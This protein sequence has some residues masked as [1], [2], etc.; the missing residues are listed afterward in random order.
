MI[1]FRGWELPLL[2]SR[3]S[4]FILLCFSSLLALACSELQL[5]AQGLS[6]FTPAKEYVR[7]NG[8]VVAIENAVSN[9]PQLAI[10]L[11]AAKS[12]YA[13]QQTFSGWAFDA[14]A[15]IG[16]AEITIDG[17][18]Y[19]TAQ[20][21]N[22]YPSA[23]SLFNNPP[24][25]PNI[26]WSIP[27]N[28][29]TLS[30]GT[31]TLLVTVWTSEIIAR[32]A[33]QSVVFSTGNSSNAVSNQ[34]TVYI[35]APVAEGTYSSV[36]TFRGWA[37]DASSAI[38]SI[39][40][41]VDGIS[42]ATAQ[43][44]I[45]RPDVCNLYGAHAGCPNVGWTFSLDTS[46]LDDGPHTVQVTAFT[47]DSIPRQTTA[48]AAFYSDN[49]DGVLIWSDTPTT[50]ATSTYSGMQTFSGWA[51]ADT[52]QLAAINVAVDGNSFGSAAYGSNRQDACN[53][54]GGPPGCPN[55]GW[56]FPLNT[57]LLT[58]GVHTLSV[59][60][61]TKDADPVLTTATFNFLVSNPGNTVQS[62]PSIYVD[63]PQVATYF[64]KQVFSG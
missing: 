31:H 35:D 41:A 12:Q 48:F 24:G 16:R 2:G 25:C 45:G 40:I 19:G 26:G 33:T 36:Q 14:S 58:N 61:V 27:V 59:T 43:Y 53:V 29:A 51:V 55:V 21:G 44:G 7:L 5:N 1:A 4:G 60:A 32:Q 13:G 38:A 10:G 20:Y 23:C 9:H 57:N 63:F 6:P 56:S 62:G 28:T 46:D 3:S 34:S 42:F 37:I 15:P 18:A 22:P 47:A 50:S 17:I 11:P 52:N 54:V 8:N 39:A 64:D 49:E 30:N